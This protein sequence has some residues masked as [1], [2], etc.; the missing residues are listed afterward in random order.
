MK[1]PR[2]A[3]DEAPTRRALVVSA[4]VAAIALIVF[5]IVGAVAPRFATTPQAHVSAGDLTSG[6][7]VG[8]LGALG[9]TPTRTTTAA[10]STSYLTAAP[11]TPQGTTAAPSLRPRVDAAVELV[12][13]MTVDHR[14]VMAGD[15]L[16]YQVVA[17]NVGDGA[18]S[19]ALTINLHTPKGTLRCD[20]TSVLNLC[21]T[22]GDYDG[23]S[24]DP[25][26]PHNNPPGVTRLVSI[27]PGASVVLETLV[28]QISANTAGTVLHNHAHVDGV[29]SITTSALDVTTQSIQLVTVSHAPDVTVIR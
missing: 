23:S 24:K 9:P 28:V 5:V 19:G 15:K 25:N 10:P 12:V 26:A 18:F 14:L 7:V 3:G 6:F 16:T 22:Q 4:S 17:K 21:T 8:G 2:K 20:P 27:K 13:A 11:A 1:A 29:Q